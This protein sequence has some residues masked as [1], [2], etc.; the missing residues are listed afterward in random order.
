MKEWVR[1]FENPVL[2]TPSSTLALLLSRC[3][4]YNDRELPES[5][6]L[7]KFLA[8]W[9]SR[10]VTQKVLF[11]DLCVQ[12]D[13]ETHSFQRHTQ[14]PHLPITAKLVCLHATFNWLPPDP[15]QTSTRAALRGCHRHGQLHVSSIVIPW[16]L[17]RIEHS[18]PIMH[19]LRPHWSAGDTNQGEARCGWFVIL[20]SFW[21]ASNNNK[22]MIVLQCKGLWHLLVS[23]VREKH[24]MALGCTLRIWPINLHRRVQTVLARPEAGRNGVGGHWLLLHHRC[25]GFTGVQ[26]MWHVR[27]YSMSAKYCHFRAHSASTRGSCHINHQCMIFPRG[28]TISTIKYKNAWP[29]L[30]SCVHIFW[31]FNGLWFPRVFRVIINSKK[32]IK[33]P[34]CSAVFLVTSVKL[35]IAF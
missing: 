4:V 33:F 35:K 15:P 27:I 1:P 18:I 34:L 17:F 30:Y 29:T 20:V 14:V 26:K 10:K 5:S 22:G 8:V 32:L 9:P 7:M 21:W 11:L 24:L 31:M 13:K 23:R 3:Y 25:S 6:G 16:E 2:K 28:W 12:G 19:Y